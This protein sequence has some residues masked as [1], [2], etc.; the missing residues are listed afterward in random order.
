[1]HK[2]LNRFEAGSG[3]GMAHAR[4]APPTAAGAFPA[5]QRFLRT[6]KPPTLLVRGKN[7]PAFVVP[8]AEAYRRDVPGAELHL[9]VAGHVAVEEQPVMNAT[10]LVESLDRLARPRGP[11]GR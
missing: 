1:M 4:L 7:D 6:R 9:L 5:W 8:G 3:T 11:R 2:R 10:T